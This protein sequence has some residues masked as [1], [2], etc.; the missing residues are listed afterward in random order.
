[1]LVLVSIDC[2]SSGVCYSSAIFHILID[3]TLPNPKFLLVHHRTSNGA[4][5]ENDDD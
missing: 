3:G 5:C 1:M 2:S 4:A